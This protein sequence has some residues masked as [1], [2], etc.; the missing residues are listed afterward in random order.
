M[1]E[2]AA[3]HLAALHLRRN[4]FPPTPDAEGYF[5]TPALERDYAEV[6]HCIRA[7]KGIVLV[8]GE[9]GMGKSTFVRH[10]LDEMGPAGTTCALVF[11]TFLQGGAL[12]KA[13]NQ[14]FG[15]PA[16]GDMAEDI[17]TLNNFLL[18]ER[19]AERT[20]LLVID[21]AQ[22]LSIESLELVRL[23]TNLETGQEKLLQIVLAGQPEL[24]ATLARSE[25]RQLASR[26]VKHMRID[27]I[28]EAEIGMYFTFRL[29][30]AGSEG[31]IRLT[32]DGLNALWRASGGNLRRIHMILD[33]C[34]YGLVALRRNDIDAGLVREAARELDG[35]AASPAPR[36]RRVQWRHVLGAG[37]A[38]SGLTLGATLY[39]GWGAVAPRPLP[40]AA[41]AAAKPAVS[42]TTVGSVS[43]L[44]RCLDR[45]NGGNGG[46]RLL[47]LPDSLA[48]RIADDADTC[49]YR[50]DGRTMAAWHPSWHVEDV[51]ANAPNE[52][53]RTL[54]QRLATLGLFDANDTLGWLGPKTHAAIARF[55][56]QAGIGQ[57]GRLD[58]LT[59]FL[60]EK[61]GR[62]PTQPAENAQHG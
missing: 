34:L 41:P 10:L 14:D 2:P 12:L 40:A 53:V 60:I 20:C 46:V 31:R 27:G 30:Q 7:H 21:D 28:G 47:A 16:S 49:L 9:V 61:L 17:T 39:A 52:A 6:A 3:A 36:Q 25:L 8:T 54:Q 55:R 56:T 44:A 37:I 33:R 22:N 29:T 23:L 32:A 4:P 45:L 51:F 57:D 43:D 35:V 48:R 38:L 26:I 62:N 18:A 19:Q 1:S 11:N 24:Q 42:A 5:F 58:E 13:I 59:L 15:L 50:Q